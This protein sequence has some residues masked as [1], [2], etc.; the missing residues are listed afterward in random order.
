MKKLLLALL[1]FTVVSAFSQDTIYFKNGESLVAKVTEI[2]AKEVKYK[3]SENMEGPTY[4]AFKK[5]IAMI[6]YLNGSKD[7][8]SSNSRYSGYDDEQT[9]NKNHRHHNSCNGHWRPGFNVLI[10]IIAFDVLLNRP[11]RPLLWWLMVL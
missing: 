4:T 5:E 2:N 8:F 6:H 1:S 10:P 9:C 7:I 3:K 11:C